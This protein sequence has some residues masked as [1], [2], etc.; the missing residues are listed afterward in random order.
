[1]LKVIKDKSNQR[2][3]CGVSGDAFSLLL[4]YGM[5]G[6]ELFQTNWRFKINP[7]QIIVLHWLKLTNFFA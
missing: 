6:P 1:M 2:T 5:M 7:L 3:V 4:C